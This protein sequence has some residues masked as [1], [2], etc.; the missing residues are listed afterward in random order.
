MLV[1][2]SQKGFFQKYTDATS[3]WSTKGPPSDYQPLGHL[4]KPARDLEMADTL[5]APGTKQAFA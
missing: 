4:S 5:Q 3:L 1:Q 2:T